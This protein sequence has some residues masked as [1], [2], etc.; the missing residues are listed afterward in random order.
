MTRRRRAGALGVLAL[1]CL[2]AAGVAAAQVRSDGG[3]ANVQAAPSSSCQLS[4]ANPKIKHVVYLQFDN[5]H[6]MR[7]NSSVASD[8]EQ[9]PHLLDFL[10]SNGTLFTN[11]HTILISH[12]AG[13]ILSTQTGLY[14]DRHGVT[15][16]NSYFYFPP[17]G[18]PAFSTAFKYWTDLVDDATGTLDPLPNMVTDAQKNTPAPWVPFTRAGCDFGAISLANIELENTGTGPFGDMSEA[19]GTGSPEWIDAS[20]SNAAPSGTAARARALTDYVGIAVH[21]ARGGGICAANA[22][23]VANARP[24]RSRRPSCPRRARS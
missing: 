19:F 21:C 14:P 4:P 13:G 20:N 10:K 9:M 15:V 1:A 3:G 24:D 5:T 17:S 6:Y 2:V 11:D 16:S 8:L 23:N 18:I 12:T 22:T 7:D